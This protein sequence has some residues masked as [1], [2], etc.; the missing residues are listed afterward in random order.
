MPTRPAPTT[1]SRPRRCAGRRAARAASARGA[2]LV[3]APAG[4]EPGEPAG[5]AAGGD[6]QTPVPKPARRRWGLGPGPACRSTTVRESGSSSRR[7]S[8]S[9]SSTCC[10]AYQS[11]GPELERLLCVP[12][13]QHGLGQRRAVIGPRRLVADHRDRAVV[14][15]PRA[16]SRSSAARPARRPRSATSWASERGSCLTPGEPPA[17]RAWAWRGGRAWRGAGRRPRGAGAPAAAPAGPAAPAPRAETRR[18]NR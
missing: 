7:A 8:P 13:E 5:P 3:H 4:L 2:Q 10:S 11:S 6:E 9:S 16:A 14:A 15:Q 18:T 12:A 1:S 17:A